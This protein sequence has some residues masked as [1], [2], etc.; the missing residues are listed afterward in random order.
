LGWFSVSGDGFV[1]DGSKLANELG[2]PLTFRCWRL[3][4]EHGKQRPSGVATSAEIK[5][6]ASFFRPAVESTCGK[7]LVD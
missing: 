1:E 5:F 4:I 3:T 2:S 6:L 7:H